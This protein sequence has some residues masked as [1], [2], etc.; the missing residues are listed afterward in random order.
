MLMEQRMYKYEPV[1][2]NRDGEVT[3]MLI[4]SILSLIYEEDYGAALFNETYT[5][6]VRT[7]ID[8]N[9]PDLLASVA[10][11]DRV[12][13]GAVHYLSMLRLDYMVICKGGPNWPVGGFDFMPNAN[14]AVSIHHPDGETVYHYAPGTNLN[15]ASLACIIQTARQIAQDHYNQPELPIKYDA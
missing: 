6:I 12:N 2:E 7:Y 13:A 11:R 1:L 10:G 4:E 9:C 5:G 8:A 15:Q 3:D 14:I